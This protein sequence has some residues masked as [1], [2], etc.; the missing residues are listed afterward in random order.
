MDKNYH[1]PHINSEGFDRDT[2]AMN[3][4]NA[5]SVPS[6]EVVC[7]LDKREHGVRVG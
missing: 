2:C 6:L 3:I 5:R 4:H 7:R 1:V